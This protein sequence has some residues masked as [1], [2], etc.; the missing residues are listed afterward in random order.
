MTK[1]KIGILGCAAIAK[2]S[3]I[4]AIKELSNTFDLVCVASRSED[5]AIEFANLFSCKPVIGYENIFKED[6]DSIY[7]PLPT[8]LHKEWII[9][10]LQNGKHVYAEK[11]IAISYSDAILMVSEAKK[12]NVALM[13]GYMF[14]YHSQHRLVK[15]IINS[16]QIGE[17]RLFRSSFGFPPLDNSNFRYN[18]EIGGGVIH[19]AAGYP[20]R[21]THFL[22]GD[23]F[24]VKA[25]TLFYNDLFKTETYGSA[26]LVNKKGVS[27]QIAFGFDNYYQC[28]YEIWGSKGKISNHR[29]FTPSPEFKPQII[30]ETQSGETQ[31]I[32]A[33]ACNHFLEAMN[34]FAIIILES[35]KREHHYHDIILQSISLDQIKRL[36]K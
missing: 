36:S 19:D 31:T 3:I 34:E 29:A 5:K 4:P 2:R 24:E 16:G 32:I 14:Q 35:N 22:L 21:A 12:N 9:K 8:G 13:E 15:N 18:N 33:D 20:L 11:S 25:S 27:A 10:S 6:I 28:N 26:F 7:I 30:L 1:I 23:E 17:I